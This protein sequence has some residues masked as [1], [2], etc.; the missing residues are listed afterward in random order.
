[1]IEIPIPA[2]VPVITCRGHQGSP[3]KEGDPTNSV[4]GVGSWVACPAGMLDGSS[5]QP[6]QYEDRLRELATHYLL[7]EPEGEKCI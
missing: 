7:I 3:V 5:G 2:M 6:I 1:M 4:K